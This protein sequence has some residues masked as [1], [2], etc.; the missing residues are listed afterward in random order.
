MNV[1]QRREIARPCKIVIAPERKWIHT[2]VADLLRTLSQTVMTVKMWH[3]FHVMRTK[4]V[5]GFSVSPLLV[6]S[7]H[8]PPSAQKKLICFICLTFESQS[9]NIPVGHHSVCPTNHLCS[10]TITL[11]WLAF[12]SWSCMVQSAIKPTKNWKSLSFQ[13][14]HFCVTSNLRQNFCIV[15]QTK[16]Y[17][18]V[19]IP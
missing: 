9:S 18:Y 10:V 17:I 8:F 13:K 4:R 5:T 12:I 2:C 1:L 11:A 3:H 14:S 19:G 6:L 15:K 7:F 16:N